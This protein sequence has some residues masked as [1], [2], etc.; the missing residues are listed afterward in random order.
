MS[1]CIVGLLFKAA[2]T[3]VLFSVI[4]LEISRPA[5]T[6]NPASWASAPTLAGHRAARRL[7]M[8]LPSLK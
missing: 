4:V 2:M 6:G 1:C 3:G 8:T 5:T 7:E